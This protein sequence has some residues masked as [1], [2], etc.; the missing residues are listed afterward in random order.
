MKRLELHQMC[1][2]FKKKQEA[3]G[4]TSLTLATM[5]LFWAFRGYC[6]ILPLG[7]ITKDKYCKVF[8]LYT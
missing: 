1:S 6:T 3:H 4:D 5:T 8:K 7:R 2:D